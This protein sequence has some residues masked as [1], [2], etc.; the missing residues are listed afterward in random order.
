MNYRNHQHEQH[1]HNTIL[2]RS[3][4][5]EANLTVRYNLKVNLKV[6]QPKTSLLATFKRRWGQ[7]NG[8]IFIPTFHYHNSLVPAKIIIWAILIAFQS[9]ASNICQRFV[10]HTPVLDQTRVRVS[11]RR[12]YLHSTCHD[13]ITCIQHAMKT[14]NKHSPTRVQSLMWATDIISVRQDPWDHL[15]LKDKHFILYIVNISKSFLQTNRLPT[16]FKMYC[17]IAVCGENKRNAQCF[18]QNIC[19]NALRIRYYMT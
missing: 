16:W 13:V 18:V 17:E 14:T 11:F 6:N 7:G 19:Y 1:S 9:V 8:V 2:L 5:Q 3:F 15:N 12:H 10:S 4:Q